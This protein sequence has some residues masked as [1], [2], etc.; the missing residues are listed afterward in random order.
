MNKNTC[1]LLAEAGGLI[2]SSKYAVAF[3]G[4]GIS[5]ESGLPPFRGENGIWEKFDPGFLEISYF[6][7]N[8]G[9]SWKIIAEIFYQYFD[10]IRPNPAHDCLSWLEKQGLLKSVIT[11]NIDDLHS[12]A[13]SRSIHEF[14]GNFK[15]LLC[16][17]CGTRS[18]FLAAMLEKIPPLCPVC[19]TVLKPDFVFFGEAI[20]ADVYKASIEEIKKCDLVI[21]VGTTGTVQPAASLPLL[22]KRNSAKIIEINIHPSELTGSVT[23]LFIQGKAGE[24]MAGIRQ[25][26][27]GT[28]SRG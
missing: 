23:D 24:I 25:S 9:P 6:D 17:S 27:E 19:G 8:P 2:R 22:A 14:H 20:P 5:V 16:R 4:A 26:I 15:K 7:R 21:C 1:E 13:G 10:R 3:T 12:A 18:G 28:Q 11:Q